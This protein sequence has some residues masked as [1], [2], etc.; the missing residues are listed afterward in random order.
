M[1]EYFFH[2]IHDAFIG[3]KIGK[4]IFWGEGYHRNAATH[5]IVS[6]AMN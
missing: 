5:I 2:S 1:P 3:V 6:D 4:D